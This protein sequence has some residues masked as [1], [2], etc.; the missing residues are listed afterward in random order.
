[1]NAYRIE[2]LLLRCNPS[3][4][5]VKT[6]TDMKEVLWRWKMN[7]G[8]KM[9][10]LT[11]ATATPTFYDPITNLSAWTDTASV[12]KRSYLTLN[13]LVTPPPIHR[14]TSTHAISNPFLRAWLAPI[15]HVASLRDVVTVT[16]N[17]RQDTQLTWDDANLEHVLRS[18][19]NPVLRP[20]DSLN[21]RSRGIRGAVDVLHDAMMTAEQMVHV[22]ISHEVNMATNRKSTTTT[23]SQSANI[24]NE[25][26]W[27]A[28]CCQFL[29]LLCDLLVQRRKFPM[30]PKQIQRC[31]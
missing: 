25:D 16:P 18:F 11:T 23:T 26:F 13:R 6:S 28:I 3:T 7:Y 9:H 19:H 24:E 31:P 5:R 4:P 2:V 27:D 1:M 17:R 20:D 29:I 22:L 10:W 8:L 14:R 30:K 21:E 12:D 15:F